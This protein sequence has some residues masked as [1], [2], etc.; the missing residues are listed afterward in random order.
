MKAEKAFSAIGKKLERELKRR[1]FRYSKKYMFLKKTTR[2]FD[3]YIFFSQFFEYIPDFYIELRVILAIH[4]RMALKTSKNSNS[5]IFHMNLWEMGNRY[6][7][8]N[9]TLIHSAFTDLK[10]KIESY[11]MPQI[12]K[13][14]EVKQ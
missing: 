2:K 1:G 14:E 11:L 6:N 4:D 7:I 3:Y 13:L 5:Q 10:N 9:E 8:A 12:G